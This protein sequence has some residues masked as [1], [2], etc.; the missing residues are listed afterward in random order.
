[1]TPSSS[2]C[3]FRILHDVLVLASWMAGIT[4]IPNT[5]AELV[6][7]VIGDTLS[8]FTYGH[9]DDWDLWL[10]YAVFAINNAAST[11]SS[12]LTQFFSNRGQHPCMPLSL[13]VLLSAEGQPAAYAAQ[14]K[15]LEQEVQA[16]LHATQQEHKVAGSVDTVFQVGNQVLL[17]TK[18]LPDS[19]EIG[20]LILLREGPFLVA[21]LAGQNTYTLAASCT[22]Y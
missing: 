12:D 17:Q 19:V 20:K 5:Q 4:R 18:E 13:P 7:M 21:A 6:N 14:K 3:Y 10:P 9:Q 22:R 8:T 2:E 1:M 11:L 16:L 15:A